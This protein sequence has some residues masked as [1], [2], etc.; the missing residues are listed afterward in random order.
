MYYFDNTDRTT[1]G[2]S[3]DS[4]VGI[5]ACYGLDGPGIEFR[6]RRDLLR[7]SRPALGPIQPPTQWILGLFHVGKAAGELC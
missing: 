4:A 6:W 7:P 1:F 2:V 3:R 5:A